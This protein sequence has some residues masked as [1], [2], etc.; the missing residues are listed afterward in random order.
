MSSQLDSGNSSGIRRGNVSTAGDGYSTGACSKGR[1]W[2]TG[3]GREEGGE[4]LGLEGWVPEG[5]GRGEVTRGKEGVRA[6]AR[7]RGEREV[8]GGRKLRI[9][10]ALQ[11]H[12]MKMRCLC[13]MFLLDAVFEMRPASPAGRYSLSIILQSLD[14]HLNAFDI[15]LKDPHAAIYLSSII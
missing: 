6:R 12:C 11:S 3:R 7:G 8:V 5:E 9:S 15:M 2:R 10:Y 4:G 14:N 13:V 1:G